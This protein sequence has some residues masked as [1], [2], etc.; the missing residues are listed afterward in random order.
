[1]HVRKVGWGACTC[2]AMYKC[3]KLAK[4]RE[5]R[6]YCTFSARNHV[7][8]GVFGTWELLE[9]RKLLEREVVCT[10]LSS[11]SNDSSTSREKKLAAYGAEYR[12]EFN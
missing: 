3:H 6:S 1:M 8:R 4:I 2:F 7:G 10:L 5:K 12:L 11:S 9:F